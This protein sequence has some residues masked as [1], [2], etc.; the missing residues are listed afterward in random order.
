MNK[1]WHAKNKMPKK[2]SQAERLAWHLEHQKACGCR[3]IPESLR[4]L[5]DQRRPRTDREKGRGI[6]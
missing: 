5:L 2:A 3:P 6:A 4:P 1:D